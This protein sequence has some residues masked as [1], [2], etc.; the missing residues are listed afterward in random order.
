MHRNH[1]YKKLG[2]TRNYLKSLPTEHQRL[3]TN[4]RK[5]L[6]DIKRCVEENQNLCILMTLEESHLFENQHEVYPTKVFILIF[7]AD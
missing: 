3:L 1:I 6:H 5:H 2:G 4:Y 7:I